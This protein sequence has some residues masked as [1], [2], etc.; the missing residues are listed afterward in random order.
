MTVSGTVQETKVLRDYN[1]EVL[2]KQI[3]VLSHMP[4]VN[5]QLI[6]SDD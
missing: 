6:H 5:Y 4:H 1:F 2:A 3:T